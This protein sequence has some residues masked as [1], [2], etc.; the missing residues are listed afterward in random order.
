MKTFRFKQ[1]S[2]IVRTLKEPPKP[3]QKFNWQRW[4]WVGIICLVLGKVSFRVYKGVALVRGEGQVE[5]KKQAINFIDDIKVLELWVEEGDTVQRGDTLFFYKNETSA[6]MAANRVVNVN[7]PV[8]WIEKEK[9]NIRKKMELNRIESQSIQSMLNFKLEEYQHQKDLVLLGVN[10]IESTL[11]EFQ[12]TILG[13]QSQQKALGRENDYYKKHL[14]MLRSQ[15]RQLKNLEWS[16]VSHLNDTACYVALM[17]GI[18]GQINFEPNEVCYETHDVMTLHQMGQIS[19]KAY[20][21][22]E[23]VPFVNRG[24][25]VNVRF[26][27]GSDGIGLVHNFYVSTYALPTEFQKKYEPTERNV[28]IDVMPISEGEAMHWMGFY[29]MTVEV[30]KL[31]YNWLELI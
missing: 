19:I 16:K 9:L 20:L 28:V 18:I 27:D 21:D 24:D 8:D 14:A 13:L 11:T 7:K 22:P 26:P 25:R 30:S 10:H 4:M 6:H 2:S 3:K 5:L 17:D 1:K 15:E 12:S 29:K 31:K 23:E